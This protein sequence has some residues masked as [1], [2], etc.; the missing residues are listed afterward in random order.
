M[1]PQ[2]PAR[3]CEL[4]PPSAS[5]RSG[6]RAC[7]L[8]LATSYR[9]GRHAT[10]LLSYLSPK[11]SEALGFACFLPSARTLRAALA[12]PAW[13]QIYHRPKKM[14]SHRHMVAKLCTSSAQR[15]SA[16]HLCNIAH[17]STF[18]PNLLARPFHPQCSVPLLAFC[19]ALSHKPAQAQYLIFCHWF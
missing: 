18:S 19:P 14:T 10:S 11:L 15:L 4:R 6:S 9:S 12:L 5:P 17:L 7:A 2:R 8:G 13:P 1:T 16:A 3:S